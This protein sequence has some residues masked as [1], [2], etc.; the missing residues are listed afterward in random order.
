MLHL[1][2]FI[3]RKF[4]TMHGHM[5]VKLVTLTLG[6]YTATQ[7][8]SNLSHIQGDSG[9]KVK[10]LAVDRMGHCDKNSSYEHVS[11]SE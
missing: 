1:V 3:I 11:N 5:N 8:S 6:T 7:T 9:R 2:G 10:S 4:V